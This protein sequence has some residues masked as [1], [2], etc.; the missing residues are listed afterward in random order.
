MKTEKT[1]N[2]NTEPNKPDLKLGHS[3]LATVKSS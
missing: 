3:N 1:V 2:K